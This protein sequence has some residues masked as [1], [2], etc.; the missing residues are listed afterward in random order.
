MSNEPTTPNVAEIVSHPEKY[1]FSWY[2]DTVQ[3]DGTVLPP[4]PLVKHLDVDLLRATFGDAVILAS[5]DGTSR[6]VTNQ[7]IARDMRWTNRA[8]S[9][10]AIKT[11]IVEN[12]LGMKAARRVTVVEKIVV[13]ESFLALDGTKHE[14]QESA[15]AASM[16][17]LIDQE[18]SK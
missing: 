11:A 6:H 10:D 1:G 12:M 16:A 18:Q 14:T 7:R 13:K 9:N 3:K 15:Q 4:V 17:W 5:C 8:V 2:M